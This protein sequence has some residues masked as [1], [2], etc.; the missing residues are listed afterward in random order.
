MDLVDYSENEFNKIVSDYKGFASRLNVKDIRYIPISAL[1]GDNIVNKSE[2]LSW[3]QGGTLLNELET[4]H[5]SSDLN[6]ID[7]RFPIQTVIRPHRKEFQDFR[8]YAGRVEGGVFKQGDNVKILPSGYSTKIKNIYIGDK[9]IE[10][11][12]SPMSITMTLDDEIDISRGDMI[13]KHDNLPQSSSD[14]SLILTWM[15][16]KPL[17]KNRKLILKHTTKEVKALVIDIK[18]EININTLHR[19]EEI[20]ELK[21][22]SIGKVI[23]KTSKPLFFDRYQRNRTTG[24]VILIDPETY[25]TVGAGMIT[26]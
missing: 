11:A 10:K 20:N 22:N 23:L 7:C 19:V 26:N 24:S 18:Y 6:H 8:G 4:V 1:V 2:K 12:F 14:I 3:Y 17:T 25:E 16:D 5:V 15:N 21:L 9:I 13:V